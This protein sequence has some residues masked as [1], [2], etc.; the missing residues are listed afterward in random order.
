MLWNVAG[1]EPN[2]G[3]DWL[4]FSEVKR[5]G[6][7][8]QRLDRFGH[9]L[10]VH[11]RTSDDPYRDSNWTTYSVLQGPKS[12]D[13]RR[14]SKILLKNHNARKPLLAQETLWSGNASHIRQIGR[15]CSEDDLRKNA[16]VINMSAA[17]FVFA[18]DNGNSSSGFSGSMDLDDR[19]QHRYDV[20]RRVWDFMNTVPFYRIAPRQDLVDRGYCLAEVGERNLIY[21]DSGGSV[22]V[23]IEG[24]LH[25]RMD[26]RS[27]H[28]RLARRRQEL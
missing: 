14:L 28:N 27:G 2:I 23:Q 11:N 15:D 21:L 22:N 25:G 18:D 17:A 13:R 7:V 9:L 20:I 12:I 4:S 24:A 16:Y 5:L 1:P 6:R 3:K 19:R 10:S 26:Q 8:I